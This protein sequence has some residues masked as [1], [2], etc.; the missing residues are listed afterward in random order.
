MTD[1]SKRA[2]QEMLDTIACRFH[3]DNPATEDGERLT[4]QR[5]SQACPACLGNYERQINATRLA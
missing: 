3:N 4:G 5:F 2:T 1:W